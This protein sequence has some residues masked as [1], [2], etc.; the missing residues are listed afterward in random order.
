MSENI[1]TCNRKAKYISFKPFSNSIL[2]LHMI[3]IVVE[4][5]PKKASPQNFC[6][7][8]GSLILLNNRVLSFGKSSLIVFQVVS[9]II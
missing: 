9:K 6:S 3:F 8:F 1:C 2:L 4:D 5:N 7:N